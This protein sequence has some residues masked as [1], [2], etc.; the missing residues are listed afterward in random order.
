METENKSSIANDIKLTFRA[1]RMFVLVVIVLLTIVYLLSGIYSISQN[2]IGVHERLGKII[3]DRVMPGIHY[4]LP[5]PIDTVYAVPVKQ[6]KRLE[7]TD[8]TGKSDFNNEFYQATNLPLYCITG[9]NNIINISCGIQYS[10]SDPV[11]YLF[12]NED[13]EKFLY[14]CACKVLVHYISSIPVD[15]AL[16]SGKKEIENVI[17]RDVQ[18]ELDALNVGLIISFV[19]LTKVAPPRD[20]QRYFDDVINAT[21]DKKEKVSK[22][23]AYRNEQIPSAKAHAFQR[24]K[25]AQSYSQDIVSKATGETQRFMSQL[26][27]YKKKSSII[28]RQ[29]Y[30]ETIKE[31]F[32]SIT[33]LYV[34]SSR[35]DS[36]PAKIKL[37]T[38]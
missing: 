25:R 12:K 15:A 34:I 38:K 17:K 2:E 22:A 33:D 13:A 31:V 19:E 9:D 3:N 36:P 16:T 6:V 28:R 10:I 8:F 29:W 18:E 30:L 11:A 4:A 20:V 1:F 26:E 27:E 7:I 21:I 35:D 24:V 32:D 23:E 5:W 14:E 37:I